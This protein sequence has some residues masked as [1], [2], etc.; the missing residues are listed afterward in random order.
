[1]VELTDLEFLTGAR[2]ADLPVE[3]IRHLIAASPLSLGMVARDGRIKPHMLHQ[4]ID[5]HFLAL[6]YE[7][8]KPKRMSLNMP[9]QTGK[10]SSLIHFIIWHIYRHP[11]RRIMY[12]TYGDKRAITVGVDTKGVFQETL[13]KYMGLELDADLASRKEWKLKGF[14]GGFISRGINESISG[15]EADLIIF[16]DPYK[17]SSDAWSAT[18]REFIWNQWNAIVRSRLR[19]HTMI[20]CCHTR[21]HQEDLTGELDRLEE[22]GGDQWQRLRVPA[23]ADQGDVYDSFG[24]LIVAEGMSPE[25]EI[26]PEFFAL[27]QLNL[28]TFI[29]EA[30]FQQRPSAPS[31][32][33][34]GTNCFPPEVF[35]D[36]FPTCL[37]IAI[38]VDPATGKDLSD[39][40]Y[41]AI[42]C[43]GQRG[44]GF[45]Y[46]DAEIQRG[47]PSDTI[48]LL[49]SFIRKLH[50][51][52]SMI[53]IES[54]SFQDFIRQIGM[55]RL[56]SHGIYSPVKGMMPTM[57]DLRTGKDVVVDKE[58][59]IQS[60]LDYWIMGKRLRFVR[61]AGTSLLVKQLESF[62][63]K[64]NKRDGPDALEIA[65]R[66]LRDYRLIQ[67]GII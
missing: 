21:W 53:G 56:I 67:E 63:M 62:P 28:P 35:V 5:R 30:M 14:H 60:G 43:V 29:W 40:D 41:A 65:L 57:R 54:M 59:R 37:E 58:T 23:I 18:M 42:V 51:T 17:D 44:D 45:L 1:M 36:E 16:D 31:G 19:P 52:V 25:C 64:G 33:Q 15:Y 26:S 49:I 4:H 66:T 12:I 7:P 10:T 22:A 9:P 8:D 24:E 47:G 32:V 50:Q 46:V 27:Q 48:D 38:G 6:G 11:N 55:E 39:G 20:I 3:L 13:G 61:G 34:W 2:I